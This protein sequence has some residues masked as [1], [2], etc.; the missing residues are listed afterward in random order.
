MDYPAINF[1]HTRDQQTQ[2]Y[3]TRPGPYD[4]WLIEFGYS[5]ALED[6]EAEAARLEAIL[7]R[8]AEPGLAFGNDADDMRSPGKALDPRVNI[9]DMSTDAVAY[10]SSNMTLMH[11][12]LIGM[13][14]KYPDAGKSYE[15]TWQGVGV[16]LN[17]WGRSAAVVSRFVGGVYVDRAV[18]GQDGA[19]QPFTPVQASK[20]REAMRVLS[21]QV[22]AADAF[23]LPGELLAHAARQRRGFDHFGGTEDPK[24]HDAVMAIQ[25][26]VLD[27]LLHPV[28]TKRITDTALYGNEYSLASMMNDLTDAM[29]KEDARKNVNSM[30]QNLQMNYVQRLAK[31]VAGG[32]DTPSQSMAVYT[33]NSIDALLARKRG[34]NVSTQAHTQ[35]L[36][37]TI[38]KALD[39]SA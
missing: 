5:V 22:F 14:N 28:V 7:S 8:S 19:T 26:G 20:Q 2:F 30:R 39:T 31:M 25:S 13:V 23:D 21:N 38:E 16:M 12:T 15:E 1:A 17:L 24:V 9:Y 36:R 3:Q 34:N 32:Y 35:N 18:V 4:D 6:P 27:H 10:A 11:N 29:F 33:L 37:R